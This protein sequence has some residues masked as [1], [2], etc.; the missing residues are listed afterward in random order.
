MFR[1]SSPNPPSVIQSYALCWTICGPLSIGIIPYGSLDAFTHSI[2]ESLELP[3][4]IKSVEYKAFI[5]CEANHIAGEFNSPE[6]FSYKKAAAVQ[7][8]NIVRER[9]LGGL[10]HHVSKLNR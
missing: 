6:V 3:Q 10:T 1:T 4:P 2:N 9:N 5:H 7:I 8:L